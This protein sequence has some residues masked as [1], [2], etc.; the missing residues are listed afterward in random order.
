MVW[1]RTHKIGCGYTSYRRARFIKKYIVCNYGDAGNLL[2]APMYQV[3][4]PCSN[5]PVNTC[6]RNYPGL[7]VVPGENEV[8]RTNSSLVQTVNQNNDIKIMRPSLPVGSEGTVM[9]SSKAS[10]S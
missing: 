5:C 7:C 2:N 8:P 10:T 1:A 3:G 4:R 9:K 6:S